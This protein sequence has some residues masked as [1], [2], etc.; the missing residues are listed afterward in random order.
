MAV[1]RN[2]ATPVELL[3]RLVGDK[4]HLVRFAVAERA[5]P[6]AWRVALAAADPDVRV[7]LAQRQDLDDATLEALVAD[8][9]RGVRVSVAESSRRADLLA[10]LARDA[11]QHVRAATATNSATA[12]DVMELLATDRTAQVRAVAAQSR[13][14]IPRTVT[15]LAADRSSNVRYFVLSSHPDRLDLAEAL[16]DDTASDIAY[17]ARRRLMAVSS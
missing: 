12:S 11:D 4:H 3:E 16:K 13:R 7:V 8:P 5:D 10:R 2:S 9:D 6:Q 17:L 1:A 14:L 15:R